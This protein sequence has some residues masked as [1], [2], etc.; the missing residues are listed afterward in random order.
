MYI[1]LTKTIEL[2]TNRFSP[3]AAVGFPFPI[4]TENRM[5]VCLMNYGHFDDAHCEYVI[6]RPDTPYPWINYLGS[7]D[8]FSLMS[9][10]SGGYTF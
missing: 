8:F 6:T 4:P 3:S 9:N 1:V 7:E 2:R 5:E 10:T